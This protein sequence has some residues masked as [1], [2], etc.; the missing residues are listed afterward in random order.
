MTEYKLQDYQ[1]K[2]INGFAKGE[3]T[4][5]TAARQT[6]KST[7]N[8]YAQQWAEMMTPQAPFRKMSQTLVDGKPWYTIKCNTT[9][10]EFIRNQPGQGTRWY[11]HIDTNW[12]VHKTMF[13]ISEELYIQVGLKFDNV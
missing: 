8:Q 9:V 10:G 11:E 6:G 4:V 1:K 7:Y 3:I 13:D 5:I 2:L 12:Y